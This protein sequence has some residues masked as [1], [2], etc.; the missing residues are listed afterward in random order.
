MKLML[1][2]KDGTARRLRRWLW[3]GGMVGMVAML[4]VAAPK[5][6]ASTTEVIYSFL[7]DEDGEYADT[8]LD[9]DSAGNLYGT[10]VLG[11]HFGSGTVF[12]LAPVGSSWVHTVLYSFTSG[13]D[14]AEPYK[15]VTVDKAG[16][17]Y[18]T[19][20]AGGGGS[21]EG[22]CGV[23]YKLTNNGGVWTQT[24]LH[25]FT[26]G[27]DGS[28]PGSRLA[29]D[30]KGN[31]YGMAPIGG[32]YG[33]GTIYQLHQARD[34]SWRFRVIHDFT[35][36]ADGAAGSAGRMVGRS[37]HLFGVA[38]AGG[39]YGSGAAFELTPTPTGGWNFRVIYSFQGQPDAGFP[40]GALLFDA[41]NNLYGTT[42][43][44]GASDL[45]SVYELSPSVSGEWTEQVL[46]SFRGVLD[47]NSSISNL[48][49]DTAGN[50][51]GTTSEGGLGGSGTI[52]Q[53]SHRS[54]SWTETVVHSFA[55]PP[56]GAFPYSGMVNGLAG[57]FYGA[58]VHGGANDDG[59][60]YKFT[61]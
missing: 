50:L 12:Q 22:G 53:L 20:V 5:A 14:G 47:G 55:G 26:G 40:Y 8:D 13:A 57:E 49:F 11:G 15:G 59:S 58:T 44:D 52:F 37:G 61:P 21:C 34:G 23:A 41:A 46:Y 31:L 2:G 27:S 36:G 17:L 10:T 28:G 24:V 42:Y 39:N 32:A 29:I 56:D 38:T 33:A 16:N 18:G 35:G 25:T 51:Y 19:A 60:I 7:G 4:Q 3:A 48:V 30:G 1:V 54:V 43:Y 6:R 9:I 45:G